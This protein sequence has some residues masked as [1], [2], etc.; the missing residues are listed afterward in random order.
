MFC[1][2]ISIREIRETR[3]CKV[4]FGIVRLYVAI[5]LLLVERFAPKH[6]VYLF[7]KRLEFCNMH[8]SNKRA[9]H[10]F[11]FK[12]DVTEETPPCS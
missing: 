5:L 10:L 11:V 3:S 7:S 12:C 4:C 1:F 6:S 8:Y 2:A 9:F